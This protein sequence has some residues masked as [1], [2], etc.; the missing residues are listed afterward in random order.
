MTQFMTQHSHNLL[1]LTLLDQRVVNDDMLLPWQSIEV[2]I[3]M[4]TPFAPVNDI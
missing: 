4:R 1:C 3:A 2:R